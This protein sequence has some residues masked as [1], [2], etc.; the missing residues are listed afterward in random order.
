MKFPIDVLFV[1]DGRVVGMRENLRPFRVF[2]I[3]GRGTD[4][5][6]LAASRLRKSDTRLGDRV[7]WEEY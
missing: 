6:E 5:V 7:Q 4:A 2:G 1:R 3:R